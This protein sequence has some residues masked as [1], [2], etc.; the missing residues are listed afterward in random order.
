MEKRRTRIEVTIETDELWIFRRRGGPARAL[1]AECGKRAIMVTLEEAVALV[2][3]S[4]RA[5]HRWAESGQIH[6][7]E[8]AEGFLLVCPDALLLRLA[9]KRLGCSASS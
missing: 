1:C 7:K 4:S 3:V 8:T 6:F 9:D 2:G 5:I